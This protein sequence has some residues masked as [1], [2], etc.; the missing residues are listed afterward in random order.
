[1]NQKK[2]YSALHKFLTKDE[3]YPGLFGIWHNNGYL[4]ASDAYTAAKVHYEDYDFDYEG[5]IIDKDG[6]ELNAK[7]PDLESI[8]PRIDDM[9]ELQDA[10]VTDIFEA[11]QNV[12]KRSNKEGEFSAL[13]IEGFFIHSCH[14]IKIIDLF[15]VI[16]ETPAMYIGRKSRPIILKSANCIA[17][18]MPEIKA[19]GAKDLLFTIEEA[20]EFK[21]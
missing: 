5:Q 4:Y 9:D 18:V 13:N 16:G 7:Y 20:L 8:I 15:E 21:N 1:M 17:L 3:R 2:L 10:L 11:C 14:L 19:F 12:P 6:K